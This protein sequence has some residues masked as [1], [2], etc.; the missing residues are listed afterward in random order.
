MKI[1]KVTITGADDKTN[2]IDLINLSIKY[3]FVE[4]AIL[5][6]NSRQGQER[7]PSE[8]WK[9]KFDTL[10]RLIPGSDRHDRQVAAHFCGWYSSEVLENGN[11]DLLTNLSRVFKRVQINYNF[12]RSKKWN[13]T[14]V[15]KYAKENPDR[16]IIFQFNLSNADALL[17]AI[18]DGQKS[19]FNISMIQA[20]KKAMKAHGHEVIENVPNNVHFLFDSS[21]GNGLYDD[22]LFYT[23]PIL[24]YYT[25]YAGGINCENVES[26]CKII[27]EHKPTTLAY[28]PNNTNCWID[29]ESGVRTNNEFDL[30]K[31][32][33]ILKITSKFV[34]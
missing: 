14:P 8:N 13:L 28:H 10:V 26:I 27:T 12:K 18:L 4:W 34:I 17:D 24:D 30:E 25:G 21:G 1:D 6:S 3:P 2:Q 31:V 19:P 20:A 23:E 5:F 29:L 33:T 16:S 32:E 9:T 11:I 15:L 22:T 7:Y